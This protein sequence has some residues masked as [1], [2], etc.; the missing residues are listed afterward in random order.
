MQTLYESSNAAEAHM[1]VDLLKQHGITAEIQGEHLQGAVGGLPA[2]GLVRLVVD[3]QDFATAREA[4][5]RWEAT[6]VDQTPT[7]KP[8][9]QKN[10]GLK[11]FLFGLAI[12][13]GG[14]YGAYRAPATVDGTDYNRD[15]LL[16]EKWTYALNGR[17][18]K[19]EADRN[20]DGKDDYLLSYDLRGQVQKAESDDD[21][22]GTF[23]TKTLFQNGN[24]ISSETDT[25]GDQYPELRTFWK[26]GVLDTVHYIKPTTGFPVRVEHFKLGKLSFT[27]VDS[28]D[29]GKLDT[30]LTYTPL[31]EVATRQSLPK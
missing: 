9:P 31:G 2:I 30:R 12:G 4:I 27:D 19:M 18:Q 7:I 14:L 6:E 28:D 25:D 24:A 22:D 21:F 23:E 26:D 10:S 3:E 11:G 15:G 8:G 1:L 5:K 16:D 13:V 29:N 17:P 20:L